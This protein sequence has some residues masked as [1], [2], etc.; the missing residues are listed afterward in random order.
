M[1]LLADEMNKLPAYQILQD[2]G[3]F[4]IATCEEGEWDLCRNHRHATHA[5]AEAEMKE[6]E[7][8]D[9]DAALSLSQGK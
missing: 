4:Y 9:L 6:W 7:A 2:A 1:D 8:E 3:G 5:E